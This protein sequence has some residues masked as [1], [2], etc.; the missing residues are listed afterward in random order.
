MTIFSV[1][2]SSKSQESHRKSTIQRALDKAKSK[3]S[4]RPSDA[5]SL[6]SNDDEYRRQKAKAIEKQCRKDEYERLE[7]TEFR[8]P[9]A[10][11]SL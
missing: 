7:K 9:G 1:L 2:S 6:A 8:M 4:G 11:S 5:E 3:L 10:P